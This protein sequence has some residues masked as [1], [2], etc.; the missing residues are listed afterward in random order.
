MLYQRFL[1]KRLGVAIAG[2]TAAIQS[3]AEPIEIALTV[4]TIVCTY[5]VAETTR[6]TSNDNDDRS[7]SD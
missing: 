2:I 6:P 1:S 7:D 3:G 5:I 4:A